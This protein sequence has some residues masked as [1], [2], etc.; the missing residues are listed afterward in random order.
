VTIVAD[1]FLSS[2]SVLSASSALGVPGTVD[3]QASTSDLSTALARL[4]EAA[5]PAAELLRASCGARLPG[6]RTSSLVVAGRAGVP[7][8][9]GAF[10]PSPLLVD[11]PASTGTAEPD[12][13]SP[14]TPV[15]ESEL[16]FVSRWTG[17]SLLRAQAP[18]RCS[19]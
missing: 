14:E 8:E 12:A 3:V 15:V 16:H 1:V 17:W 10:L 19:D 4:P 2:G 7:L 13:A 9:P 5:V 6:G 18:V 11:P